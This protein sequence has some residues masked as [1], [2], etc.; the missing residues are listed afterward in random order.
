MLR[1]K[2]EQ[3]QKIGRT[4]ADSMTDT[5]QTDQTNLIDLIVAGK[6]TPTLVMDH[7]AVYNESRR[8]GRM[9]RMQH[10]FDPQAVQEFDEQ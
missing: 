2:T 4:G 5:N 7:Q 8:T 1:F 6:M 9:D 10:P 3:E